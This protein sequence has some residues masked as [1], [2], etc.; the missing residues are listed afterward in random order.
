MQI[1]SFCIWSFQSVLWKQR[2]PVGEYAPNPHCCF[3]LK[4]GKPDEMQKSQALVQFSG[5]NCCFGERL[6]LGGT[7]PPVECNCFEL[8]SCKSTHMHTHKRTRD[9]NAVLGPWLSS[10]PNTSQISTIVPHQ[11]VEIPH[12]SN[13]KSGSA[14]VCVCVCLQQSGIILQPR[15]P[16]VWTKN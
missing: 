1:L 13:S 11:S 7:N 5:K 15:H 6:Y 3:Y 4:Y 9:W 14:C 10:K 2:I 8:T 16:V 12:I